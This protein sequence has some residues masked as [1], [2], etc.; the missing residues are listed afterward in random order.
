MKTV[1]IISNMCPYNLL[2][3]DW[4]ESCLRKYLLCLILA[5]CQPNKIMAYLTFHKWLVSVCNIHNDIWMVQTKTSHVGEVSYAIILLGWRYTAF[6]LCTAGF[7]ILKS[8]VV[9][10]SITIIIHLAHGDLESKCTYKWEKPN[11]WFDYVHL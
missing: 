4:P 6:W 7:F 10:K 5:Y 1:S 2:E 8:V 3:V 9:M 11:C